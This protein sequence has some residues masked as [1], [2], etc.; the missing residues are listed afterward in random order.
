MQSLKRKVT[1]SAFVLVLALLTT[2]GSTFAWFTVSNTVTVGS[3]ELNVKTSP[4]LLVRVYDEDAYYFAGAVGSSD[5]RRLDGTT[6]YTY[7]ALPSPHYVETTPSYTIDVDGNLVLGADI[8][9]HDVEHSNE[10]HYA[11]AVGTTDIL[12]GDNQVVFDYVTDHF[13]LPTSGTEYTLEDMDPTGTVDY[14]LI[15]DALA[16]VLNEEVLY[17]T[18]ALAK[19][20]AGL[21]D[22]TTYHNYLEIADFLASGVYAD[23]ASWRLQPVTA[24]NTAYA[25]VRGD[26]LK[27]FWSPNDDLNR[28]LDPLLAGDV[29]AA[30][31]RII[32]FKLWLLSQGTTA[33]DLYLSD[34]D[35]LA[36]VNAMDEQDDA[37]NATRLSVTAGATSIIYGSDVDYAYD[38]LRGSVGYASYEIASTSIAA[39]EAAADAGS[40]AYYWFGAAGT[41]DIIDTSDDSVAY[42]F[43]DADPDYFTAGADEFTFI[44]GRGLIAKG[45]FNRILDFNAAFSAAAGAPVDHTSEIISAF[46]GNTPTILTF[47]I[48]VDGWDLDADNNIIAANMTV[49]FALSIGTVD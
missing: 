41:S 26:Q 25:A 2:L 11:G 33:Y 42:A 3:I 37:I 6:V 8:I 5:I 18:A 29:N 35:I 32:E 14:R 39:D 17:D 22:A 16:E 47:R 9:V 31:G 40:V 20:G 34:L 46:A 38:Y 23:I 10:F 1:V 43:V 24:V 19:T 45:Q 12:D 48:Y 27:R 15:D 21:Y 13:E 30:A 28:T 49:S 36:G 44:A 7:V 4:S